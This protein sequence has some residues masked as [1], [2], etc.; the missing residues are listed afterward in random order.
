MLRSIL[1]LAG[2]IPLAACGSGRAIERPFFTQPPQ[3]LLPS[4]AR[5]D[6]GL[7]AVC[8]G[9]ATT[10]VDELRSMVA[11]AC[12]NPQMLRQDLTGNCTALQPVRATFA[13]SRIDTDVAKIERPFGGGEGG[14]YRL[15]PQV[16][17]D[18][19]RELNR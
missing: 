15:E 18:K 10:G 7:V 12:E 2:L 16:P 14:R 4:G 9:S 8:Y 6:Q 5:V 1:V 11:K 3:I 19:E 17:G 13:C